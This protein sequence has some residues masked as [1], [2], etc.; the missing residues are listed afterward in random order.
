MMPLA[1]VCLLASEVLAV[2]LL[3]VKP[4]PVIPAGQ[5]SL[6]ALAPRDLGFFLLS[7]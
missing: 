5:I 3:I 1:Y 2:G 7:I 4:L 6:Y